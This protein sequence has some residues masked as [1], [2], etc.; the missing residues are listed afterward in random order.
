M[1]AGS[2]SAVSLCLLNVNIQHHSFFS[3][4]RLIASLPCNTAMYTWGDKDPGKTFLTMIL[5]TPRASSSLSFLVGIMPMLSPMK[6]Q[7]SQPT[8]NYPKL[9][10]KVP[11]HTWGEDAFFCC[12]CL[13]RVSPACIQ[14]PGMVAL[15]CLGLGR[16]VCA[17]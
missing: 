12:L 16:L 6:S 3:C 7:E 17:C 1:S 9:F 8:L 5:S 15:C 11:C 14:R 10:L 13:L 4:R 2:H